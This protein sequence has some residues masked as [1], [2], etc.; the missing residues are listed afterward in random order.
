MT[1]IPPAERKPLQAYGHVYVSGG[2]ADRYA[3]ERGLAVETARRELTD[4]LLTRGRV[5]QEDGARLVARARSKASGVDVTVS[6][7]REG[8]MLVVTAIL[9]AKDLV[10]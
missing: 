2:A 8:E 5:H 9:Q 6:L 4:L 1:L 7:L 10:R 3:A